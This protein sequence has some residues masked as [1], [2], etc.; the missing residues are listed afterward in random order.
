MGA[1]ETSRSQAAAVG[2]RAAHPARNPVT[3]LGALMAVVAFGGLVFFVLVEFMRREPGPYLGM[4]VYIGLPAVLVAGLLLIPAGIWWEVRRRAAAASRGEEPPPALQ[5]DFGNPKHLAGVLAFAAAT[6]AILATLGATGYGAMEFMEST[7]FCST[8]HT[9]MQPQLEAHERSPHAEID[10]TACHIGPGAGPIGTGAGRYFE[11]KI[12]GL[13]QTLAVIAGTYDRPV[14]APDAAL[15]TVAR[16]CEE[17][18]SPTE[19]YG[20]TLEVYRTFLADERNT[21]HESVLAFRVGDGTEGIHWHATAKVYY[22]PADEQRSAVLWAGVETDDGLDEWVN[23]EASIGESA[24]KR[25]LMTCIDCHNRVGHRI[26]TPEELVDEALAEGRLDRS[27]PYLKREAL[28]ILEA[29]GTVTDAGLLHY[30]WSQQDWFDQLA[31]FYRREYP[32]VFARKRSAIEDAVAELRRLSRELLYPE[33][34]TSW[35]TYPDNL[36]HPQ[37]NGGNP[38][39]FRCHGTLVNVRTGE[40]LAGTFG[41][42]GCLACHNFDEAR[43]PMSPLQAAPDRQ[44]CALCHI[45]LP[46]DAAEMLLPARTPAPDAALRGHGEAAP[47]GAGGR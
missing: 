44:A 33:M 15:D 45:S 27:L 42:S 5:L 39:C 24:G 28:R 20:L 16:T 21:P 38:G 23:P 37:A 34:R 25:R 11:A 6:V 30:Q 41:G 9:V 10:C 36:E 47:Q 19:N 13:R 43:Q 2:Q 22:E 12:G 31:D 14:H 32:D 17:C 4:L 46:R 3:L 35:L 18:H 1:M 8:C 40:R 7:T 26:P 29:D